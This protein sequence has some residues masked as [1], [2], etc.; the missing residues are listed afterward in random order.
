MKSWKD[1]GN[2]GFVTLE[3]LG[4]RIFLAEVEGT[5]YEA[6]LLIERSRVLIPLTSC[7]PRQWASTARCLNQMPGTLDMIPLFIDGLL[8]N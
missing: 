8:A 1:T 7:A 2:L 4:V 6:V 3:P 5:A